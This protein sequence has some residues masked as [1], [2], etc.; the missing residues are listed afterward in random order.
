[1]NRSISR[2]RG[3]ALLIAAAMLL[4]VLTGSVTPARAQE[5]EEPAGDSIG[6]LNDKYSQLDQQIQQLQQEIDGLSAA[7]GEEEQKRAQL[8][9]QKQLVQEQVDLLQDKIE[10][11]NGQ[12]E[13]KEAYIEQ[14]QQS[15]EENEELFRQRLRAQYMSPEAS[16]LSAVLGASSFSEML[17]RADTMSRL[18]EHDRQLIATLTKEKEDMEAAQNE[19]SASKSDLD[20]SK[21][22]LDQKNAVLAGEAD[23]AASTIDQLGGQLALNAQQQ[24]Q[25]RQE[26]DAVEADILAAIRENENKHNNENSGGQSSSS[27][28]APTPPPAPDGGGSSDGG[29]SGGESS[30]T[31]APEPEPE[32]EPEPDPPVTAFQWPVPGFSYISAPYGYSAIYG[33]EW[34]TGIDIA[35]G[36][37][38]GSNIVAA[39]DG[40]VISAIYGN[41][42][43]GYYLLI[44][45]GNSL[46]SLYGHCSNLYVGKGATVRRGQTIAAV[47]S[48]GNST[49]PHL[50]FEV[51][52][53][54][55]YGSDVNPY[56]YL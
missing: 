7:K 51:R 46:Y 23:A 45:H 26:R 31:P 35:G 17:L 36:G 22:L 9:E 50:H 42:G 12:V 24:V 16:G 2:H 6:A 40:E 54:G 34:H 20:A 39:A 49:G 38:Y 21:S 44:Y 48:T 37:I 11:L 14:K 8:L 13:E 52:E 43:Y 15:I 28:S 56:K 47:G 53:G 1:M 30:S 32:P 3:L 25:Y 29:S 33:N 18:A 19:L 10:Q 4:A 5:K 27:S 41:Y 55:N